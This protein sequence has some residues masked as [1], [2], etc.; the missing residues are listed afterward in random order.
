MLTD[1]SLTELLTALPTA[2]DII[3]QLVCQFQADDIQP[4]G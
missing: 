1:Y 4:L 2:V 3:T